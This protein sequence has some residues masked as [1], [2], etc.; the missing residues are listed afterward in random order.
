[1]NNLPC[2]QA[3][4]PR[5][6]VLLNEALD[7]DGHTRSA[8]MDGLA[9]DDACL[10]PALLRVLGDGAQPARTQFAALPHIEVEDR[11]FAAGMVVG[12]YRLQTLLGEGGMGQVWRASRCDDGPRRDVA[13]KLP[14][15]DILGGVSRQRF[16]RERDVLASL[17]HPHIAQLYD[18]GTGADGHPYLALELVHGAPITQLC[19][20][21]AADLDRRVD[22]LC[23]VLEALGWA[24]QRLIVHRDVKPS[25][26]MV[27]EQGGVKL[28]DFGIAKLLGPEIDQP[29]YPDLLTLPSTRLATPAYAAP[30]LLIGGTVTVA[31]DLFSAGVLLYELCTGKRPFLR[32]P[33]ERNARP[34][35]LASHKADA[36][37]AG[38]S[39]RHLARRL[40][41]DLDAVIAK[42]LALEP[43]GRYN[44][45]ESFCADL[46]RWRLGQP[47]RARRSGR[48]V[49]GQK[50]VRRNKLGVSLAGIVVLALA[51]G[52]AGT[53]WQAQRAKRQAARANAISEFL[54]GL[55]RSS[56]PRTGAPQIA[57]MTA[58]QL[59][60]LGAD[61]ADASF[62]H[63]PET[64]ISLLETLGNIYDTLDD[65]TRAEH[66]WLRRLDLATAVYGPTARVVVDGAIDLA[67]SEAEQLDYDQAKAV[68]RRVERPI[69][70]GYG[71]E[72]LLRAQ[73]L[74][75]KART[76]RA[77]HGAR[78]EA[79]ADARAAIKIFT[80]HFPDNKDYAYALYVLASRQFEAE[81]FEE[82]LA[83]LER[84]R[85]VEAARS[86]GDA[87]IDLMYAFA[88]AYRIERLGRVRAA[89]ARFAAAQAQADRQLGPQSQ[90]SLSILLHRAEL[91]DLAGD[92][93]R[94][95]DL[96]QRAFSVRPTADELV[97]GA[98]GAMLVRRGR[99][100]EAI[101]MLESALKLAR[102]QTRDEDTV[103]RC[104]GVLGQA[105]DQA[106][107]P[108]AAALLLAARDEW[109]RYGVKGGIES[110][111]A[112]E[113]WANYLWRHGQTEAGENEYHDILQEAAG[114]PSAP[115]A[116]A[117]AGLALDA[118]A[119]GDKAEAQS[120]STAA[121]RVLDATVREHD[122]RVGIDVWM[123][124]AAA[125]QAS[126]DDTAAHGWMARAQT[127]AASSGRAFRPALE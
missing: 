29:R 87:M 51:T 64:E 34:A 91:A 8:W 125:L 11:T 4:W 86:V 31:S 15:A 55:F 32:V 13:L 119:R 36:A 47:V 78:D 18:A 98:Y 84:M 45:A 25:N 72:S 27:M 126:G 60:D 53:A 33:V 40:R 124:R 38:T 77:T 88:S 17:C 111:A 110:L 35:P 9:G 42:A 57:N 89:D 19:R 109:R 121:V 102:A 105:Y 75:T 90:W 96:L 69:L 108:E 76:L 120:R 21:E 113:R 107:R 118:L 5:F 67:A 93:A 14:H 81:R 49:R 99:G 3:D 112:R 92:V 114:Q 58:R 101:P 68:L 23:Q 61:R 74:A 39:E 70:D 73:W 103:R 52:A 115:A 106:G 122:V 12:P 79:I 46:R 116:L 63:D 24:H 28:L 22:L 43:E 83:T 44:S 26:V 16:A 82:S 71:G 7:R 48:L 20:A 54:L 10:K 80:A 50:F 127:L 30:E 2:A 56:D 100:A 104:E 41:G 59:L 95:D 66:V 6:S 37:S 1:M 123:A 85:A 62:D 97:G 117:Q 65:R 94:A